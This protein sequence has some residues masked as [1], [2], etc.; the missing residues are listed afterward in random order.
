LSVFSNSKH[1]QQQSNKNP[2]VA[3]QVPVISLH[4]PSASTIKTVQ[5]ISTFQSKTDQSI[6][7]IQSS[8]NQLIPPTFSSSQPSISESNATTNLPV[9]KKQLT[10][11]TESPDDIK[12]L[13][14]L[15]EIN[16]FTREISKHSSGNIRYFIL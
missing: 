11:T 5:E 13:W 12:S 14:D 16:R 7:N 2:K 6:S 8:T 9:P 10:L 1:Q 3:S 4:V 15:D